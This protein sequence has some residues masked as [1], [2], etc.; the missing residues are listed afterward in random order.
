MKDFN[1]FDFYEEGGKNKKISLRYGVLAGAVASLVVI[2]A[3]GLN[4]IKIN[5]LNKEIA[6]MEQVI[7]SSENKIKLKE[8]EEEDRKISIMKNYY[9]KVDPIDVKMAE[10]DVLSSKLIESVSSCIPKD[11][12]FKSISMDPSAIQILGDGI[13]RIAIADLEHKLKDLDTVE[14]VHILSISKASE[15][16]QTYAFSLKCILKDVVNNEGN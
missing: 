11:V 6:T 16:K 3:F 15:E 13:N 8:I 9:T 12:Y 7:N 5:K 10:Q 1:F 14:N 4:Y 2:A